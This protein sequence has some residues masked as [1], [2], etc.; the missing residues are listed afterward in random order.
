MLHS[1][2]IP[3]LATATGIHERQTIPVAV[4][5]AGLLLAN[6]NAPFSA[7]FAANLAPS[8]QTTC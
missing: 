7:S 4:V 8:E 6:F 5:M 2:H 1:T 3:G